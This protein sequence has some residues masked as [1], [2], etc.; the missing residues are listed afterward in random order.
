MKQKLK[1]CWISAGVSSF[2]AGYLAENVDEFIYIDIENQHPD[3]MRFIKDCEKELKKP[4]QILK[5]NYENTQNVIRQFR[6]I[7]GIHGAKCTE[8]LKKRFVKNGNMSIVI[9]ILHMFGDL[10]STSGTGQTDC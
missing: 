3:S 8:I 5:S 6:F 1:V 10:I 4:I 2:I 9:M 7:N